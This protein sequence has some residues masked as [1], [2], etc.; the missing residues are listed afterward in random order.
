ME[1]NKGII[2]LINIYQ[3]YISCLF[4]PSCRFYPSCSEYSKLAF[5]KYTFF[6]ALILTIYRI[7]RCNPW[8]DGGYDPL[9]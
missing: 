3:T 8:N 9:K 4:P 5:G 1:K 6:K 7:C 2:K